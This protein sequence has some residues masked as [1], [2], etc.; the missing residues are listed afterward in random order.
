M[1]STQVH[2]DP[3]YL[4]EVWGSYVFGL[5]LLALRFIVRLRSVGLRGFQGDDYLVYVVVVLYTVDAWTVTETYL[6]GSNVDYTE[7]TLAPLADAEIKQ[8]IFGSKTEFVA[9]CT[10]TALMY[11]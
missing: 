2:H 8:V 1:G 3:T 6:N 10:Y 4:P 5:L 11:V 9:W 7:A